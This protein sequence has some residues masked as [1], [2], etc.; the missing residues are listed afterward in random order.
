MIM[1]AVLLVIDYDNYI[2]TD[3][4]GDVNIFIFHLV[5]SVARSLHFSITQL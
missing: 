4:G 3:Y 5:D 1:L 2:A